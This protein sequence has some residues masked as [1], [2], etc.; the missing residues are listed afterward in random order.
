MRRR[1]LRRWGPS[2]KIGALKRTKSAP[3]RTNRF[4]KDNH[5]RNLLKN[6]RGSLPSVASALN[7]YLQLCHLRS[8]DPFPATERRAL[9]WSAV[10]N[11]TATF[12]N[13]TLHL[14]KVCF[15]LCTSSA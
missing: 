6:I 8:D 5:Q 2:R 1:P 9:D 14:Q 13:H 4:I 15:F 10:F 11:D 3:S 12:Y 7:C